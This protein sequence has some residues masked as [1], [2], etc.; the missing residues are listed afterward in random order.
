MSDWEPTRIVH[1][2]DCQVIVFQAQ[3]DLVGP[4]QKVQEG[5]LLAFRKRL[6]YLPE[7]FDGFRELRVPFVTNI[8][9]ELGN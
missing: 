8:L 1:P 4:R 3:W 6:Y 9:L 7:P 5:L 2:L